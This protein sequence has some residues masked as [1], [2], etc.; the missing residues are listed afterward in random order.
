MPMEGGVEDMPDSFK[1]VMVV[2]L[3]T[4]KTVTTVVAVALGM[5]GICG[6]N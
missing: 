3:T 1:R 4:V 5:R 2:A 6:Q